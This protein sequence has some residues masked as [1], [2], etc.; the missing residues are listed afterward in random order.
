M[1]RF[2]KN[3]NTYFTVKFQD[4]E[5]IIGINYE[6]IEVSGNK[7]RSIDRGIGTDRYAS[8]ITVYGKKSYIDELINELQLLRDNNKPIIIDQ[9]QDG[10]FGDHISYTAPISCVL[11]DLGVQSNKSFNTFMIDMTLLSTGITYK[12]GGNLPTS[13]RCLNHIWTGG[14]NM[15]IKTNETYNSNNYFVNSVSDAYEFE[16]T[17]TINSSD[18]AD[19]FNYWKGIRGTVITI[20]ESDFGVTNMFGALGGT[21]SHDVIIKDIT[22]EIISS[23]YRSTTIK[24][25]K[26]S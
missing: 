5:P 19:L 16:G 14:V 25:I 13:L 10:I 24:L 9:C 1:M 3:D 7:F 17:Y 22:Y 18:N 8:K 15:N 23:I 4:F 20:N 21:G 2:K 12:A 6:L 26:V 11:Y